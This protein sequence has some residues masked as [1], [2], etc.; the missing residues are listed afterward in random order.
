MFRLKRASLL[1]DIWKSSQRGSVVITGSPGGGK[2]WTIAQ[3]V[4]E[5]KS[6][7]R[8]CLPLIAEDF[9]V[10]SL[11]ELRSALG[12]KTDVISFLESLADDSVLIID[13][14]DA[15]RSDLS[16][17]TFRELI[18]AVSRRVPK[19][20][21]VAS[22]RTFDLQQSQELQELFF[23]ARSVSNARKFSQVVVPPF[24]DE[25]MSEVVRQI[26]GL[27]PLLSDT[28]EEFKQLLRNPFNLH[29]AAQLI[30]AGATAQEL[31][32]LDS[33]VQ[34]LEKYWRWRIETPMDR[35]DRK[36]LLRAVL[37]KM[38][39][40]KSLSVSEGDVYSTGVGPILTALQ[41]DEILRQ[42]FTSRI[43]FVH[44]IIF[45]Y[46]L[47]R[48]L[49]DED[50][51]SGFIEADP[52]R[53]IFFRPSLAYFFHLLWL[54]DR[55]MFWKVAIAFFK[56]NSLPER[57]KIVPAVTIYEAARSVDDLTPFLAGT[58]EG[59]TEGLTGTLRAVQALGGLQS[60]RRPLWLAVILRLSENPK[61]GFVNEYVGLLSAAGETIRSNERADIF[62]VG[63]RL[64][65]WMWKLAPE[66]PRDQAVSLANIGAG[67]VL[68]VILRNYAAEIERARKIVLSVLDRYGSPLSGPNE[69]FWLAHE[70]R[71][72]IEHDPATA[73]AVYQR[74]FRYKESSEETTEMG[75]G[76]VLSLRSNRAQ[77]FDMGRYG[78][79]QAFNGF[80]QMAAQ[81][82][83]IAAIES[84]KA[85]IERE[86]P[87]VTRD[88]MTIESFT[89]QL[90]G[91]ELQYK[92]DF[93]EIWDSGARE[94]VSLRLLDSAVHYAAK[95]LSESREVDKGAAILHSIMQRSSFAVVWKRL[96]Q[97]TIT[98]TD[99]LFPHL[100]GLLTVPEF[101]SAPE[102]TISV[103]EVLKMAYEK[104]LVTTSNAAAIEKAI[105]AIR[106]ARVVLRYEKPESIRNRLLM[107][108]PPDEI[109]S[110]EA[111][112][113]VERLIEAKEARENKP[114][115]SFTGGARLFGT[116]DWLREAGVDTHKPENVE[117][118]NALKPLQE[119]ERKYMNETPGITECIEIEPLLR[120]VDDL[121][122]ELKPED[123]V[124]ETARGILCGTAESVLKNAKLTVDSSVLRLCLSIALRGASDPSPVFNA[125]YDLPFDMPSWGS[126]LPR[127]EAAQGLSHYLWNWGLDAEVVSALRKLGR[128]EVPAVRFQVAQG[129]LGFFKHEARTEFWSLV[130]EMLR[131]EQT[132]GVM[133]ALV[134][135]LGRAGHQEPERVAQLLSETIERGL[136]ASE[137]SDLIRGLLQV[138]V[139]LYVARDDEGAKRQ[140][141]QFETDPL[142]N[143]REL[144]EEVLAAAYY[145]SPSNAQKSETLIRSR[146]LLMRVV[147]ST[148]EALGR[149]FQDQSQNDKGEALGKLL[150]ILDEVATR[151]FFSLDLGPQSGGTPALEDTSRRTL[152]FDLKPLI[153]QLTSRR[154][155]A[156]Q[157][158]LAPN[159]AHYLM[160]TLN[161]VLTFDP[162]TVIGCAAA[163]CRA[164]KILKYQFDPLAIEEMVKL[165]E[166]VLADHR[167]VLRE[168]ATANALGEMLDIFVS[169][170]WSQAMSLTF[171]LDQAVR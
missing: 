88:D 17:R 83:G 57:A 162:A 85:E 122:N 125:K 1:S 123:K 24:S 76:V 4:R 40:R 26:P 38:V 35:L 161:G 41:S 107:C 82:A 50:G 43:A 155:P 121:L 157:H 34:L 39:E 93:S 110:A 167:E 115:H 66:L 112:A 74:T 86:Q 111:R 154:P 170:G 95:L 97:A 84:V 62:T 46:A 2:S 100:V 47:A 92:A 59:Q 151:V 54:S 42:S 30:E 118:L 126:P 160:Q 146:D 150:R 10:E 16:Q 32:V 28:K 69:A 27:V 36:A 90:G 119:F 163:V 156:S 129:A 78:L 61:I 134:E 64:L 37:S 58:D 131:N 49:L 91:T 145:L 136:P 3:F 144:I 132:A 80:L 33:Q 117:I 68:P 45:D 81:E 44:N 127:I 139:G 96:L 98:E 140:L 31:S 77:D 67:R 147:A 164:A 141:L 116:E 70:I 65:Q 138:L 79:E 55:K 103:G 149:L 152:Y 48:L 135:A 52:S 9:A 108:I 7:K 63:E 153:E 158:L 169:A 159:T 104:K 165:V 60:P 109:Q 51:V 20:S 142:K 21:I 106:D 143:H 6:Q 105:L 114:Y 12:F 72:V 11:D 168:T 23:S 56:S 8:P 73:I 25:E 71:S 137:R 130:R 5:C 89:F 53:T 13:G 128:D 133:M 99:A 19:C 171:K 87:M 124:A 101:I 22:I 15:L 94:Y 166:H 29:L 75:G 113:I 120:R 14:L 18:S 148:Y 102:T